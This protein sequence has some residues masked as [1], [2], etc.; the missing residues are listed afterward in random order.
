M[1]VRY[2]DA[3]VWVTQR[4]PAYK[5][6]LTAVEMLLVNAGGPLRRYLLASQLARVCM[7]TPILDRVPV[8][9]FTA[10]APRIMD[11]PD[12]RWAWFVREGVGLFVDAALEADAAAQVR[13]GGLEALTRDTETGKDPADIP[14][15][16]EAWTAWETA[17][18]DHLAQAVGAAGAQV[19]SF[20]GHQEPTA[21]AVEW[22]RRDS[23]HL[24]LVVDSPRGIDSAFSSAVMTQARHVVADGARYRARWRPPEQPLQPMA[25]KGEALLVLDARPATRTA[26]LF[27]WDPQSEAPVG[28][29]PVV[30]I[31]TVEIEDGQ[32]V[33]EHTLVESVDVARPLLES[34]SEPRRPLSCVSTSCLTDHQWTSEWLPS[35]EA[36]TKL[37]F[38]VDVDPLLLLHEWESAE[39]RAFVI[40]IVDPTGTR[41]CLLIASANRD[42]TWLVIA[43]ELGIGI[44]LQ[45]LRDDGRVSFASEGE[46]PPCLDDLHSMLTHLLATESFFDLRGAT[47]YT[48]LEREGAS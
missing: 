14:R 35:L 22:A 37:F 40:R 28:R 39:A 30:A 4:Y 20:N 17:A 48:R 47:Q 15:F 3:R 16:D 29:R 46:N 10:D 38:L 26:D 34:W 41:D 32:P 7:Q 11:I 27:A 19:L 5:R 36:F 6:L 21:A 42:R 2:E 33:M 45:A 31:R 9:G 24:D 8:T 43:D 44:L 13:P 1:P 25:I 18:Y 23:P 12:R